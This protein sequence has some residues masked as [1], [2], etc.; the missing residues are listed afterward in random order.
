MGKRKNT[1][2]QFYVFIYQGL[3]KNCETFTNFC[4]Q[5]YT[6]TLIGIPVH[7]LIYLVI[8]TT[9]HM[10]AAQCKKNQIQVES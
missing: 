9:N 5:K 4:K 10:P 7:L 8:Q 6:L 1:L 3:I 2:L